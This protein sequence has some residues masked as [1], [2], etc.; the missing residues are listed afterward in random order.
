[1]DHWLVYAVF[2]LWPAIDIVAA[3]SIRGLAFAASCCR[4]IGGVCLL[5]WWCCSEGRPTTRPGDLAS[6]N[7]NV[8]DICARRL[9]LLARLFAWRW[10]RVTGQSVHLWSLVGQ[11]F[12]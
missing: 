3:R 8:L 5:L 11:D 2:Q 10:S 4:P 12:F 9:G 6:N 1:M 7:E